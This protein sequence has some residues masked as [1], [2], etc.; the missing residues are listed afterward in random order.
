MDLQEEDI[1]YFNNGHS[2]NIKF[3]KRHGGKPDLKNKYILDVGCGH[4]A[5]C[6]DLALSGA[7][8]VVGIDL[9]HDRI[10]FAQNNLKQNY[11]QLIDSVIFLEIDLKDYP[12]DILFDY[13]VSKDSFEHIIDLPC[14][15][16]EMNKRLKHGGLIF[17]GFGPLY[18]D[19]YGD[20][21]RTKSVIPWGHLMRSEKNI[22]KKLNKDRVIPLTSIQELGVNMLSLDDYKRIFK[23]S[24]MELV[25]FQL[26]KSNHPILLLF[27]L[28]G[29][30]PFLTEFFA[31]NIY[32]IFRKP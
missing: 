15:L 18:N 23:E 21:K 9:D 17:S 4:G 7:G 5:L 16:H 25:S 28:I 30:I 14:M 2:E 12:T 26:N 10:E 29:K 19:F 3:W 20:H 6:I 27:N 22:L 31:H 1:A 24:E 32:C 11:P 13:I 8:K